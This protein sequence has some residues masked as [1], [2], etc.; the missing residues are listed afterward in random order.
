[1]S[2]GLYGRPGHSYFEVVDVVWRK[3]DVP[4]TL[5]NTIGYGIRPEVYLRLVEDDAWAETVNE[6]LRAA[7]AAS[8]RP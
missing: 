5:L 6:Q 8:W 7:G 1:M 4:G 2:Q 3:V